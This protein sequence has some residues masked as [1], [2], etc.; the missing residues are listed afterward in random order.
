M[1]LPTDDR[2]DDLFKLGISDPRLI[3]KDDEVFIRMT[4]AERLQHMVLITC[5][6]LLVLT[7]LPLLFDPTVW[8]QRLFF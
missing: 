8:L 1:K 5:F 2:I 6:L 7:G 4:W 3:V